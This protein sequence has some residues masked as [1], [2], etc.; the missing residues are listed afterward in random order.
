MTDKEIDQMMQTMQSQRENAHVA[1]S[2]DAEARHV[3]GTRLLAAIESWIASYLFLTDSLTARVLATWAIGTHIMGRMQSYPYLAV[4]GTGPGCGKTR[5][6]EILQMVCKEAELG[7]SLRPSYLLQ[8]LHASDGNCTV[9][10]D[11]AETLR[12]SGQTFLGEL[13]NAGYRR[14]QTIGRAHGTKMMQYQ[15]FSAKAFG[16]IGTPSPALVS[17]SL[18]VRMV[19][20][21]VARQWQWQQAS[22]EGG[23]LARAIETFV[24]TFGSRDYDVLT[25][26]AWSEGRDQEITSP[27]LGLVQWL[28]GDDVLISSLRSWL[29]DMVEYRDAAPVVPVASR[30]TIEQE[31]EARYADILVADVR[32]IAAE[33]GAS[34]IATADLIEAL[35]GKVSSPWRAY[36]GQGIDAISLGQLLGIAGLQARQKKVKR[37]GQVHVLRGYD[38]SSV[39]PPAVEGKR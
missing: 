27:M 25:D 14:G 10:Y 9:L 20:G 7:T 21:P 30:E 37:A 34:W 3:A 12:A 5:V 6:L 17:R 36:R 32:A 23:E 38:V 15:V 11:E 13:L 8:R 39:A 19:R 31:R 4:C 2:S 24:A 29:A 18:I 22:V 16:L 28:T 1:Q 35:R 33:S 26:S